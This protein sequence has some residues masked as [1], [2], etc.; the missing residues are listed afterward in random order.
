MKLTKNK[1]FF[2]ILIFGLIVNIL[3]ICD[4][5]YLYLRTIFSFMFLTTI[6]GLLI[7]LML[8]VRKIG[9]WEYFVYSIGLSITFL[10]FG[11]L[12]INSTLPLV[13]IDKPLS[14]VSLLVSF[15]IFLLIFTFIAYKRNSD[16][17]Y[18][19]KLPKL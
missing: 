3:V 1:I 17:N 2:G 4:I 15:D 16:L 13:G 6:P 12:F 14:L 19:L 8:K 9:F 10:I 18:K 7:M 11:G 5:Q